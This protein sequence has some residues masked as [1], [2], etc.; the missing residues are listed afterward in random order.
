MLKEKGWTRSHYASVKTTI[1][2]KSLRRTLMDYLQGGENIRL[3]T[4][5]YKT[6]KIPF[7]TPHMPGLSH[8]A[9]CKGYLTQNKNA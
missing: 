6:Y 1:R 5:M 7:C 2:S 4:K 9:R 3:R 8:T